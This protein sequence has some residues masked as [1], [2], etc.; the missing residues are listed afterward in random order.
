[1]TND[2]RNFMRFPVHLKA[3]YLNKSRW[4]DCPVETVSREGM[5][6]S[7]SATKGI[8]A[9]NTVDTEVQVPSRKEPIKVAGKIIWLKQQ[10]G[11]AATHTVKL[12]LN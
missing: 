6:I 4:N 8:D 3:R 11:N 1:M 2:Q 12:V 7:F 10:K 9:G 5:E